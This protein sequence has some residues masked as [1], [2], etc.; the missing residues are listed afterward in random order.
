MLLKFL[1]IS[2]NNKATLRREVEFLVKTF[3][4]LFVLCFQ[5][6]K[7]FRVETDLLGL[8]LNFS[9]PKFLARTYFIVM[10]GKI[11]KNQPDFL[12]IFVIT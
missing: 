7:N 12:F 3:E 2:Y 8:L 5:V 11:H 1:E 10:R 9:L 4:R 6:N